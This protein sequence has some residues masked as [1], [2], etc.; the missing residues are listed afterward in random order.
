MNAE[1]HE[2]GARLVAPAEIHA[3]TAISATA[4]SESEI[5]RVVPLNLYGLERFSQR[6]HW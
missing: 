5:I 4:S 1:A 6:L 2:A 3:Q